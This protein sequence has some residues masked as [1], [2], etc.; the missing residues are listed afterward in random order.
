MGWR[1]LTDSERTDYY[2]RYKSGESI[3]VL[4]SEV[5]AYAPTFERNLRRWAQSQRQADEPAAQIAEVEQPLQDPKHVEVFRLLKLRP[6]SLDELSEHLDRS[7]TSVRAMLADMKAAGYVFNES[8]EKVTFDPTVRPSQRKPVTTLADERGQVVTFGVASDPHAGSTH[9]QPSALNKFIDIAY[10]EYGVRDLL[11]PGDIT[12][13]VNG[14]RG[15]EADL[16][17]ALRGM[18]RTPHRVTNGQVKLADAYIPKKPGLRHFVMGGNHDYWHVVNAGIDA[19]NALT[20]QRDDM[21]FVGYDIADIPLTD[22]VDVRMWHPSGGIPY[23]FTHK[24]Q[25]GL[26]AMAFEELTRAIVENDNPKLRIL[27]AGHLHIEAKFT[28]GPMVAAH[29]GCFEG[30]TNYLKQKGYYP[31]VG[32][33]IFR[34]WLTDAGMIQRTEYT[35]IP[36]VEIENDWQNWP[37]PEAPAVVGEPDQVKV[38]FSV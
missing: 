33:A 23:A 26:E 14:Y 11:W 8:E 2:E 3:V 15:Q 29:V 37:V 4:A 24:L 7:K 30:Q 5:G 25:K 36:F 28:R 20:Q 13:G 17:P 10:E 18:S 1:Q 38:L 35:F 21:W 32:G 31:Q 34:V 9:S 27:L 6:R 16:L 12:T 22:R 19:V